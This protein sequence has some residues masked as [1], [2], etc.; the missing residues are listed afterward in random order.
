MLEE[1]ADGCHEMM[2][3]LHP[4]VGHLDVEEAELFYSKALVLCMQCETLLT[5]SSPLSF[6]MQATGTANNP[7]WIFPS[8]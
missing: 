6:V 3:R 4:N 7:W 8:D 2:E 1:D 5:F